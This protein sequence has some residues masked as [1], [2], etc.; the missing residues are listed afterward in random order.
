MVTKGTLDLQNR[1]PRLR[2]LPRSYVLSRLMVW[3]WTAAIAFGLGVPQAW[4]YWKDTSDVFVTLHS[5]F[6]NH[7][8]SLSLSVT[9]SVL[10][11]SRP[12]ANAL[13][14]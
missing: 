1:A 5:I 12:N 9:Q 14:L 6:G 2:N 7:G 13:S 8:N 4:F 3:S 10:M 11:P